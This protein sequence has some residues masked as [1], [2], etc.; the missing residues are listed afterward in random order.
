MKSEQVG[1]DSSGWRALFEERHG[2]GAYERLLIELRQPCMTFAAI[3]KRL[4]V[5]REVVRQWQISLLPEAP[6][7]LERRRLCAA[8]RQRRRLLEDPLFRD[9]YRHARRHTV[10]DRIELVQG[11]AGYRRRMARIGT[12]VVALR[13]AR[14]MS[15]EGMRL[16]AAP[17]Y[18]LATYRGTADFVYYRL[19]RDEFLLMPAHHLR[20]RETRFVEASGARF[21]EFKNT[22]VALDMGADRNEA[23]AVEHQCEEKATCT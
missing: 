21:G 18:R 19:T 9:F 20:A 15:A 16:A 2:R 12:H 8:F 1:T 11:T 6:R 10:P 17:G 3:A 13:S 23:Q 14:P 5:T 7:G 4:G 22:F